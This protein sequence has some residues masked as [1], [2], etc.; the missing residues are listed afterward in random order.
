MSEQPI[1]IDAIINGQKHKSEA[2]SQEKIQH[3][4][5]KLLAM[6]RLIRKRK[7]FKQSMQ[8]MMHLQ[9]GDSP[10]SQTV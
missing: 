8:H 2:H 3:I 6:P 4:Q 5:K 7:R 10:P 9:I 1:V